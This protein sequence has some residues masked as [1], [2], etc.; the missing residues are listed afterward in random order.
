MLVSCYMGEH[1]ATYADFLPDGLTVDAY[2]A[3]RID[4]AAAEMEELS[5]RAA[6]DMLLGPAG[7]TLEIAYLD[8]SPGERAN[9][10][11]YE[12]EGAA[13]DAHHPTVRLLYRP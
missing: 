2:R 10:H 5:L 7:V 9:V 8:R 6:Y 13:P 3:E 12:P 1:A 11:R 4:P